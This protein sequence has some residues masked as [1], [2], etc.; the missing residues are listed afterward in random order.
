MGDIIYS[1]IAMDLIHF[2]RKIIEK[3][4]LFC[5]IKINIHKVISQ[6]QQAQYYILPPRVKI[7]LEVTRLRTP[8][9]PQYANFALSHLAF[10]LHIYIG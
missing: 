3:S 7:I 5:K 10:S 2:L 1:Q 8:N 9:Q 4:T 6:S